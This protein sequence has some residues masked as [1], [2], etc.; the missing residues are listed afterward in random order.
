MKTIQIVTPQNVLIEH[1][2]ANV[3]M[4]GLAFAIDQIAIL[5]SMIILFI[6][7]NAFGF[8]DDLFEL[9]IYVLL[10]PI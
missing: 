8:D 2:L 10:L 9:M 7:L 6:F 4:R 3:V 1:E 5:V